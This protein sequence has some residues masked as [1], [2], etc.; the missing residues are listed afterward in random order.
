MHFVPQHTPSGHVE[1][2]ALAVRHEELDAFLDEFENLM[3]G[4]PMSIM[5]A[6]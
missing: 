4:P 6:L 3:S 2:T 1:T 5:K